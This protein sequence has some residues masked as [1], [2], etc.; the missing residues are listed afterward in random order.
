MKVNSALVKDV[1]VFNKG[2]T[3]IIFS[4]IEVKF[5]TPKFTT[6]NKRSSYTLKQFRKTK[7][8]MWKAAGFGMI[9]TMPEH[10]HYKFSLYYYVDL[11]ARKYSTPNLDNPIL[12]K[13]KNY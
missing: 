6:N 11:Y 1:F 9:V 2:P 7:S 10:L 13:K 3:S 4:G 8:S 12:K 5:F